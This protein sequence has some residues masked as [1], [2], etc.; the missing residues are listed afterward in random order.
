MFYEYPF[1]S[2]IITYFF[3]EIHS[4]KRPRPCSESPF[5][6]HV[7]N[8]TLQRKCNC[9]ENCSSLMYNLKHC[10][11]H[12]V[13]LTQGMQIW[14][15]ASLEVVLKYFNSSMSAPASQPDIARPIRKYMHISPE[16]L[17][18]YLISKGRFQ[19]LHTKII[20]DAIGQNYNQSEQRNV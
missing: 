20:I 13:Q 1:I 8:S 6:I 5:R 17:G 9:G 4:V 3:V 16:P 19:P 14:L 11:C 10:F 7:E 18:S 15:D 12:I 2:S